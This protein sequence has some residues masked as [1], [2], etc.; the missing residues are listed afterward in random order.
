[1]ATTKAT[2]TRT[3]STATASAKARTKP[4]TVET[5]AV[6]DLDR[7]RK[8]FYAYVGVADLAVEKLRALP[9]VY[10]QGFTTAQAQVNHARGSFKTLP[11]SVR[12]QISALPKKAG[13]S[14]AEL[15]SRGH[16][17]VTTVRNNPNTK[18]AVRQ[19]KTARAQAKGAAT[20]VRRSVNSTSRVVESTAAKVG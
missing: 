12:E 7:V 9:E 10:T 14:Y 13:E 19:A 5:T 15:V 20:S 17:L 1:M 11:E 8:P 18:A 6:I 4:A 2:T 3:R 16:K